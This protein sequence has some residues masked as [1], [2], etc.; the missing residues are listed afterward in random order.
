MFIFIH[1]KTTEGSHNYLVILVFRAEIIKG[2]FYKVAQKVMGNLNMII[3]Q[4]TTSSVLVNM[5]KPVQ[6]FIALV[7]IKMTWLLNQFTSSTK[8]LYKNI[9]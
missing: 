3:I 6:I 4:I 2:V 9:T 5:A 1:G 7:L 8:I